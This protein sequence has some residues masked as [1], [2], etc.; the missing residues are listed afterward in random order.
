MDSLR[1]AWGEFMTLTWDACRLHHAFGI[2]LG[3]LG[4]DHRL[5]IRLG[6]ADL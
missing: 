5:Q 3:L 6:L 4:E 2:L 1:Y